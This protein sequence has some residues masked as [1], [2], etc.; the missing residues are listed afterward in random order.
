MTPH[1]IR[2]LSRQSEAFNEY[3]MNRGCLVIGEYAPKVI[4]NSRHLTRCVNLSET[5]AIALIAG[6]D[7]AKERRHAGAN[8]RLIG[9]VLFYTADHPALVNQAWVRLV[10]SK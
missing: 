5:E 8:Q 7:S 9:L 1:V 4:P 10:C 6:M 3:L 2:G